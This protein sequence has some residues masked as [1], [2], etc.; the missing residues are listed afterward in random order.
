ME[1]VE[2]IC[3]ECKGIFPV[4]ANV[5]WRAKLCPVCRVPAHRKMRREWAK[6]SYPHPCLNC[7]KMLYGRSNS[8][9]CKECD[10]KYRWALYRIQNP[11]RICDGYV[12]VFAPEHQ[13]KCGRKRPSILEHR[14]IMEQFLNR[15]LLPSEIVHHLNGIKHDN[16]PQNLFVTD[17]HNHK[18]WTL[19]GAKAKRIRDL[20]AQLSQQ[21]LPS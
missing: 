13:Q 14:L 4:R 1:T 19:L 18:T 7:G 6:S 5:A 17:A 9:R 8:L 16:R 3:Q 20:E 10:Y 15:S 11:R 21:K 2:C 12:W